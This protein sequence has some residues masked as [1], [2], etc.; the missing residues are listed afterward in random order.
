MYVRTKKISEKTSRALLCML[1][2]KTYPPTIENALKYPNILRETL[3]R[4]SATF[5]QGAIPT[6]AGALVFVTDPK[7]GYFIELRVDRNG[8]FIKLEAPPKQ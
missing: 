5:E 6:S 8:T 1:V 7:T 3:I 2:R 4:K